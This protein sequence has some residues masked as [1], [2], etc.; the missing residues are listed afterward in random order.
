[1]FQSLSD[2]SAITRSRI[3]N[4]NVDECRFFIFRAADRR[5]A[6][7]V[8]ELQSV[9]IPG[10]PATAI[11]TCHMT[12]ARGARLG[13]YEIVGL[14][15]VGGMGEVYRSWDPRLRRE[16]AIKILPP[17]VSTDPERL[18]RFEQEAHATGALNHPNILAIYDIGTQDG[19]PYVV[20][21]L[22][23]GKTL[24]RRLAEGN[25]LLHK[26]IDYAVQIADGLNAAHERGIIHR[27]L[28][29]ENLF[30]TSAERL[31]ILDFGLAKIMSGAG[32]HGGSAA[33]TESGMIV[34]TIG[35]MC[36][37]QLR[38]GQIDERSDIFSLGA[39]LY[40]MVTGKHAFDAGSAADTISAILN[41]DPLPLMDS[42]K[43]IPV[44]A[45]RVIWRCLEKRPENR[46]QSAQD[47]IFALKEVEERIQQAQTPVGVTWSREAVPSPSSQS[48]AVL[49]FVDMSPEQ[50]F[51]YFCDGMAE[52][53]IN[54]L[55][56]V[57]GLRVA[58]RSAAF[59]FQGKGQD[60]RKIGEQLNVG[61]VL[62]GSVRK[63]GNKLRITAQLVN[64]AQG[65]HLWSERYDREMDDVFQIQ[66]EIAESIVSAL[67][68]KLALEIK[69]SLIK[70]YTDNLDAY[71]HYLKG[72]YHYN[73]MVAQSFRKAIECF[74][75]AI[76]LDPHYAPAYAG[77]AFCYVL[78]GVW[79]PSLQSLPLAKQCALKAV[80]LDDSLGEVHGALGLVRFA[81]DLDWS[82]AGAELKRAIQMNPESGL[83]RI[84][85][86][87]YLAA[88]GRFDEAIKEAKKGTELDPLS[89]F[90]NAVCGCVFLLASEY[91]QAIEQLRKTLDL[92]PAVFQGHYW[93]GCSYELCER[94]DEAIVEFLEAA[95]LTGE[96][97]ENLS[98]LA[99]AY[100]TLDWK[101]YWEKQLEI[102]LLKAKA[103]Y[104]SPFIIA[105]VCA[106]LHRQDETFEWLQRACKERTW[107]VVWVPV[108]P[109]F[110]EYRSDARF[111]SFV[112]A[113]G[114]S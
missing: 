81:Y 54:A 82:G 5:H 44:E 38:A 42:Q 86:A 34:G 111:T 73:K 52:E 30:V 66:D 70:R 25:L 48:V 35:Y 62:E 55:G 31:K 15:G 2:P 100:S 95:R 63:A 108:N 76:D 46:F 97:P 114:L 21:E 99:D 40:E 84:W 39:V 13:P 75:S 57:E 12:L 43:R 19:T 71:N 3:T 89:H 69:E 26:A 106:R 11:M 59:Q 45:Q 14:L 4:R 92:D 94:K 104:A 24:R 77:Q 37:E 78:G 68:V 72:R 88:L 27:D 98:A 60:T 74:Q 17:D 41:K 83:D 112:K 102:L 36:P 110:S 29:P 53:L 10:R 28:K 6:H 105:Q 20:T 58:S 8:C 22:L 93:L 18:R 65:Q 101:G 47:L 90:V 1:M 7:F 16:I 103:T 56:R 9:T 33:Q 79:L 96:T 50:D 107:G 87:V 61:A 113:L 51:E 23:E 109:L 32:S 64:A 91:E 85:H 49:P 80:E 67:K